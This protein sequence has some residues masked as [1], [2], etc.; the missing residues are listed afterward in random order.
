MRGFRARLAD[1]E[2]EYREAVTRVSIELQQLQAMHGRNVMVNSAKVLDLLNPRGMWRFIET[3][4]EPM[5]KVDEDT[6]DLDPITGCKPVTA[7][8]QTGLDKVQAAVE[9]SRGGPP[10]PSIQGYA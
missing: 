9:R 3:D 8:P 6:S 5:P 2:C 1:H 7:K 10:P 4:T